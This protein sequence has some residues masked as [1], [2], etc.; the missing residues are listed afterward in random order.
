MFCLL[1]TSSHAREL[2]FKLFGALG[3]IVAQLRTHRIKDDVGDPTFEC[4][5]FVGEILQ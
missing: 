2:T 5:D 1:E 4:G 3:V